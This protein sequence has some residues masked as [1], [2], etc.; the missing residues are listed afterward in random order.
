VTA[1]AFGFAELHGGDS[2]VRIIPALGGKIASLHVGGREWL[3]LGGALPDREPTDAA[4]PAETEAAGGYHECFPTAAAC[5]VPSGVRRYGGTTL[6]NRGELWTHRPTVSVETRSDGQ[7]ATCV[8]HGSRMQY[9]FT[10]EVHVTGTGD[11]RMRY[12]VE[13]VGGDPLPFVWSAHPVLRLTDVTKLDLPVGAAV[14]VGVRTGSALHEMAPE[15]R[16]PHARLEKKIADFSR[17]D[18]VA[19]YYACQLFFDLPPSPTIAAVEEGADRLEL[20]FDGREVP[21]FAVSL[22]KPE[23]RSFRRSG[24]DPHVLFG[25]ALGAP[26]SLADALLHWHGAQWLEP[27]A[28]RAWSFFWRGRRTTP[29][30]P[31]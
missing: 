19:R 6:P 7:H 13:N 11:V 4:A 29:T 20:H 15:F 8:W 3:W 26:D 30:P 22:H 27:H 21:N 28:Q 17:P 1:T 23:R 25:P 24:S 10:R 2:R 9:Q 31:R 5:T 18:G 14:R 16:W 12:V